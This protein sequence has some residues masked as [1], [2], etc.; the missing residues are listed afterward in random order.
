MKSFTVPLT[1]GSNM[2]FFIGTGHLAVTE[3]KK[4]PKMCRIT[5]GMHNNGGWEVA[6]P[7]AKVV[8]LIKEAV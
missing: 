8:K 3:S 1:S 4:D 6:L 7:A 2:T 5:D